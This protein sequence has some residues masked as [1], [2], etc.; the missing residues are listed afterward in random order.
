M[1]Y[2][3]L[4]IVALLLIYILIVYNKLINLKNLVKEAFSTMDVYLIKRWEL[5]PN[6]V[7]IVKGYS[8][9]E[10]NTLEEVTKLRNKNYNEMDTSKKID[11]NIQ[12][13]K[14]ISS[15]NILE[16]NYPDLKANNNYLDLSDKLVKLENEILKSRKYYNG[17]V[18][19]YN[20]YVLMFPNNIIA[21]IFKY[22][23]EKMFEAN[24]HER[25][26]VNI[27]I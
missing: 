12:L 2:I 1:I 13:D 3:I 27:N 5:V 10:K 16:E 23:E 17:T 22:K 7:E 8:K 18:K 14:A 25:Q 24:L 15:I 6:L 21:K 9:H 20:N 4:G 19:I 26:N 11:E